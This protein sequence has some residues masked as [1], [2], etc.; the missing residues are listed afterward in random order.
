MRNHYAPLLLGP[1]SQLVVT[2]MK[3]KGGASTFL[4]FTIE[5]RRNREMPFRIGLWSQPLVTSEEELGLAH[6]QT[7]DMRGLNLTAH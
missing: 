3:V 4:G 7:L 5:D 1:W 2:L 6:V